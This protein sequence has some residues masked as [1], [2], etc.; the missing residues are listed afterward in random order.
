MFTSRVTHCNTVF[1]L[2][3]HKSSFKTGS[4]K[5]PK[6]LT[7]TFHFPCF[8]WQFIRYVGL[9]P[10]PAD[11]WISVAAPV[12]LGIMWTLKKSTVGML[13]NHGQDHPL[14]VRGNH[15]MA[16]KRLLLWKT[17]F[18]KRGDQTW[19]VA[20]FLQDLFQICRQGWQCWSGNS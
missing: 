18:K 15:R 1:T 13:R 17:D 3:P 7:R 20:A 19:K 8:C 4:F 2:K 14:C 9:F 11:Q 6:F 10:P 5:N 12:G 16:F